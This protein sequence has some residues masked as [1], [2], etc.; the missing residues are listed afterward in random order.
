M[1][2]ND[3]KH[4]FFDNLLDKCVFRL[5]RHIKSFENNRSRL[6]IYTKTPRTL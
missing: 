6:I 3:I 2:G 5:N 1:D 4:F